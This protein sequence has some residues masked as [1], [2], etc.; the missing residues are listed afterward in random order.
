M[1]TAF[2]HSSYQFQIRESSH[3]NHAQ[4]VF[5]GERTKRTGAEDES[6]KGLILLP[7]PEESLV[8]AFMYYERLEYDK[9]NVILR[10]KRYFLRYI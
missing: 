10:R 6:G 7:D 8:C 5:C 1:V 4:E 2:L 9:V 3:Q